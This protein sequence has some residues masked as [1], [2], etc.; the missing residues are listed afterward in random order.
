M[1]QSLDHTIAFY[2]A[3]NAKDVQ[4]LL[5]NLKNNMNKSFMII[6]VYNTQ[7]F[8]RDHIHC[9]LIHKKNDQYL[10][11]KTDKLHNLNI[12]GNII[13]RA[14]FYT[15]ISGNNLPLLSQILFLSKQEHHKE[16]NVDIANSINTLSEH[17]RTHLA[18]DWSGYRGIPNC[19]INEPLATLRVA[20][21]NCRHNIFTP[22][23]NDRFKPK[24]GNSKDF[25]NHFFQAFIENK[26]VNPYYQALWQI[27]EERKNKDYCEKLWQDHCQEKKLTERCVLIKIKM[28]WIVF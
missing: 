15:T 6:P 20:L 9:L 28:R 7:E 24:V 14:N 8:L 16:S 18:V 12:D 4:K 13:E 5:E 11:T 10:V 27:Y 26:K 21:Y 2:E 3:T 25:H 17:E 1:L 23:K 19:P 22:M